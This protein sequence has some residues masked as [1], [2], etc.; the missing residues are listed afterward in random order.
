MKTNIYKAPKNEVENVVNL[1]AVKDDFLEK[2]VGR[3]CIFKKPL[4]ENGNG[5]M[6][7]GLQKIIGVQTD[8]RGVSCFRVERVEPLWS[9]YDKDFIK[10]NFGRVARREDIIIVKKV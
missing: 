1:L 3:F 10:D 5:L 8:Y 7:T 2:F 4:D 9:D 6:Y